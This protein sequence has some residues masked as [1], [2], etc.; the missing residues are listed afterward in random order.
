MPRKANASRT[1][2]ERMPLQGRDARELG[3]GVHVGRRAEQHAELGHPV[4]G[5]RL[6]RRQAHQQVDD[7]ER[8][9][10][11][12][13]QREEVEGAFLV[14]AAID[15]RQPVAELRLDGIAQQEAGGE[16]GQGRADGRGEGHEHQAPA[17][18]EDGARREREHGG[19]GDGQRRDGDVDQHED[20]AGRERRRRDVA[21]ERRLLR[22]DDVEAQEAPC[23]RRHVGHDERR[24][25]DQEQDPSGAHAGQDAGCAARAASGSFS[26]SGCRRFV[27]SR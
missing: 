25:G 9:D 4:E 3:A 10:G 16:E 5:P 15:R 1:P 11:N 23:V 8:E 18:A 7:E 12:Q 20:R 24:D 19:A 21:L 27:S 22:P 26:T 2:G 17:E 14:D 6:H 13:A